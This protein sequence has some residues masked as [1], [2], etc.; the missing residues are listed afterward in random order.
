METPDPPNLHS[1]ATRILNALVAENQMLRQLV[2]DLT[3][4]LTP[5]PTTTQVWNL[6]PGDAHP[7]RT[8]ADQHAS[9]DRCAVIEAVNGHLSRIDWDTPPIW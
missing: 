3:A 7:S 9:P 6:H 8:A 1:E 4:T 2:A 5:P